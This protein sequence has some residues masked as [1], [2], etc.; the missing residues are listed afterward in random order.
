M[1]IARIIKKLGSRQTLYHVD[2]PLRQAYKRDPDTIEGGED[3]LRRLRPIQKVLAAGEPLHGRGFD[4][5]KDLEVIIERIW[6]EPVAEYDYVILSHSVPDYD[7]DQTYI[8]GSDE[9][10]ESH[11]SFE[12]EGSRRGYID[13][14][15]LLEELGYEIYEGE[16]PE[17]VD[18]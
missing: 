9:T 4:F 3:C 6:I 15:S 13:H 8:F 7:E 10:G 14:D 17:E 2:P 5:A 11:D 12:L 16:P 18:R 1:K